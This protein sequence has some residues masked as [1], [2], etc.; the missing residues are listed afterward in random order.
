MKY[1]VLFV[2]LVLIILLS[3]T[4]S[5]V[6]PIVE[7]VSPPNNATDVELSG[8]NVNLRVN[9]TDMDGDLSFISFQTNKSG[10]W[11]D[12]ATVFTSD[13]WTSDMPVVFNNL[14]YGKTYYWRVLAK[15]AMDNWT[16]VTAKFTTITEEETE[17][18]I[19]IIPSE[20]RAGRKILFLTDLEED[21]TGYLFCYETDNVY[22]FDVKNGLGI[23]ELNIEEHGDALVNIPKYA[24]KTFTIASP[25]EGDLVIDVPAN[26]DMGEEVEV[27][28]F[29]KGERISASLT[30]ISPSGKKSYKTTTATEPTEITFSESGN[31]TITT[32][33][34][35][36]VATTTIY[37][38]PEPLDI[39]ILNDCCLKV[40]QEVLIKINGQATVKIKKDEASWEYETDGD[41]YVYFTPLHPG[42]YTVTAKSLGQSGTEYFTVKAN[43]YIWVKNEKGYRVNSISEGELIFIQVTDDRG[44]AIPGSSIDVYTDGSFTKKRTIQLTGG[45]G[46]WKVDIPAKKYTFEFNPEDVEHYL[47]ATTVVPGASNLPLIYIAIA[48]I[49]VIIILSLYLLQ[50]KGYNIIKYLPFRRKEEWEEELL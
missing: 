16:N 47:P 27:S 5:A 7:I 39:D 8:G 10:V 31:W 43:T 20:P 26:A 18:T 29:A 36:A 1:K 30:L 37:I 21:T 24:S 49:V 14:E 35:G 12:I 17:H 15:D 22:L 28:V 2:Q 46:I 38:N 50:L 4:V 44:N 25:Y 33:V 19:D 13:N 11:T 45:S 32:E 6:A 34:Y 41:G 40:N 9:V 3:S 42:R 23:V 48:I